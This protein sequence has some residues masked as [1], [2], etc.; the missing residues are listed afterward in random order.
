MSKG[1]IRRTNLYNFIDLGR[2]TWYF[3]QEDHALGAILMML[4]TMFGKMIYS[5]D[6]YDLYIFAFLCQVLV[7]V[8]WFKYHWDL[9][10]RKQNL[11]EEKLD[12]ELSIHK[13]ETN[14][15][16]EV[17]SYMVETSY[18]TSIT[19]LGHTIDYLESGEKEQIDP[20]TLKTLVEASKKAVTGLGDKMKLFNVPFKTF[21]K[22]FYGG[23]AEEVVEPQIEDLPEAIE[24]SMK[25]LQNAKGADPNQINESTKNIDDFNPKTEES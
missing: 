7:G 18:E 22:T 16:F 1:I 10:N 3:F 2:R 24:H 23:D 6:I 11:E 15:Q 14:K 19:L 9:K 25:E 21:V 13:I 5:K 17:I 4:A 20:L 12:I 8:T